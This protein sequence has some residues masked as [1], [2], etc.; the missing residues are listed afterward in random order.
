MKLNKKQVAII[1]IS[2]TVLM[3]AGYFALTAFFSLQQKDALWLSMKPSEETLIER[4]NI[5][6]ERRALLNKFGVFSF[7]LLSLTGLLVFLNNG[8]KS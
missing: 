3:S 2:I 1:W 7:G 6:R 5:I 8:K 4:V